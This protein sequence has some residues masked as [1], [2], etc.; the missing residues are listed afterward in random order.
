MNKVYALVRD[1]LAFWGTRLGILAAL[2]AGYLATNG[3]AV[4]SAVNSIVPARYQAIASIAVGL[5]TYLLVH[6]ASNSDVKKAAG[7]G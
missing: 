1:R 5:L 6:V 7:N 4:Q 3:A 2:V